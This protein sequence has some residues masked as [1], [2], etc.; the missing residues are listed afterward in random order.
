MF[1][2]QLLIN[3]L[4]EIKKK[5]NHKKNIEKNSEIHKDKQEMSI[6]FKLFADLEKSDYER[7]NKV[8]FNIKY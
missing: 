4:E 2:R 1:L 6:V 3:Y 8:I 7:T 5:L